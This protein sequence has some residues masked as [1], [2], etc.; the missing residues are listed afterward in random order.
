MKQ[1]I[2]QY[3]VA[4]TLRFKIIPT[5]KTKEILAEKRKQSKLLLEADKKRAKDFK[6]AKEV[7]DRFHRDFI[8][9]VLDKMKNDS[10]IIESLQDCSTED[11]KNELRKKIS[12]RFLTDPLYNSLFGKDLFVQANSEKGLYSFAKN[13]SERDALLAFEGFTIFFAGY[14]E[15]RK[16][17][18]V[19][20]KQT[21][22]IAYRI[23][24][25]NLQKFENN[26]IVF[27][28]IM[29]T[30]LATTLSKNTK[31]KKLLKGKP[32]ED[33]FQLGFYINVW[34]QEEIEY[35][36]DIVGIIN[37]DIKQFNDTLASK[38]SEL[39]LMEK[40]YKQILG[41]KEED[42]N[43]WMFR[44]FNSDKELLK[45]VGQFYSLFESKIAEPLRQLLENINTYDLAGIHIH[46]KSLRTISSSIFD[47]GYAIA[48]TLIPQNTNESY[49]EYKERI[50]KGNKS[51]TIQSVNKKASTNICQY[52]SKHSFKPITEDSDNR[53]EKDIFET[54]KVAY[55]N[56]KEIICNA[57]S[58][59]KKEL[60]GS[61]NEEKLKTLLDSLK[62]LQNFVQP[63]LGKGDEK[64]K[65]WSFYNEFTE[66]WEELRPLNI[67]YDKVR[68]RMTRKPF[69]TDKI[70]VIFDVKRNFLNGWT[71]SMTK[72]DNGTQ[73]GGYIFRKKNA[74]GEYDYY[75]GVCKNAK[76][77]RK[78]DG[79]HGDYERLDYY[80]IDSKTFYKY[81]Y[82]GANGFEE[83]KNSLM[84]AIRSFLEITAQDEN[85][86]QLL[87][88]VNSKDTPIAM[89]TA[90]QE[91][92]QSKLSE[93]LNDKDFAD[94]NKTVIENLR[95]SILSL[96]R[97]PEAQ[98]YKDKEYL[99]F[100]EVQ[101]DIEVL[102][103][104][105][106]VFEYFQV[107]DE[108]IRNAQDDDTKPLLLFK[109]SNKD[110]SYA[111]TYCE[112]K[113]TSRGTENL[114]TMYFKT[115]MEGNQK[116]FDIGAGQI[117][118][119]EKSIPRKVTHKAGVPI[120][121]K[122][123]RVHAERPTRT[124][125][126]DLVKDK[127]YTEDNY[128]FHLS[129]VINYQKSELPKSDK[130]KAVND[131]LC[132]FN[133]MTLEYLRQNKGNVNIIGIDRGERNLI[134]VSL[135]NAKGEHLT[136]E[137]PRSY[138]L[139]G[140]FDYQKKLKQVAKNRD[141][142]RKNWTI[143][144][145]IADIK[146]GYLSQVVHE[147]ASLAVRHHAII[148]MENLSRGFKNGRFPIEHQVYQLFENMLIEKLSYFAFKKD[149]PSEGYGNIINGVQL[150][151][152]INKADGVKQ[153]GWIFYVPAGYTSKIDP[154]TG[155]ADLFNLN[156]AA[157]DIRNF[158]R[159][160]DSIRYENGLFHFEFDYSKQ[161]TK[162]IRKTT[163]TPWHLS[164]HGK[165]I[166]KKELVD[167]TSKFR[168]FFAKS[169]VSISLDK[170][171]IE[172]IC[173]LDDIQLNEFFGLFKLLLKMRN[174]YD[175]Q[176]F[177]ISPV[178]DDKPF[179]TGEGNPMGIKDA[180]ANG[181]YNIAL[182]GLYW[183]Y[184]NFPTDEN[185]YLK[186][187]KDE[188]WFDFIQTKPYLND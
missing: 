188:D 100:S 185:G 137:F 16:N 113:R 117:F 159:A 31:L 108:E 118:F 115:L 72:S 163:I 162:G 109:I 126:Y 17:M 67:L 187:I 110:L 151:V 133:N 103:R 64:K 184:F 174:S 112:G 44:G 161:E 53:E 88:D 177:I 122:N 1:F 87:K 41:F 76:I 69:S 180:D 27:S 181:A 144:E 129:I 37:S 111:E 168:S 114:H 21:T 20:K 105:K 96:S 10:N 13:E 25:V 155:F 75:L 29:K 154:A 90:I 23:V 74:I 91:R 97:I 164:S 92:S 78:R 4:K 61:G 182:K 36:N 160:F 43:D 94:I 167:L 153:N 80:Q 120:E 166:E 99:L 169:D 119:R 183:L 116:V 2:N 38:K 139:I 81:Y 171:S 132:E 7:I 135:L 32:C 34:K 28:E 136:T 165:R 12:E 50:K 11:G 63:L 124:L 93:L 47:D 40:L 107:S 152:P 26:M 79:V 179:I 147:I 175:E 48:R 18:Y 178:A 8:D 86:E 24:N 130:K 54:I 59:S 102:C 3:Q 123:E 82:C 146:K 66:L 60:A 157:K 156:G 19:S 22:A 128:L 148:V 186:Y 125:C 173:N 98:D 45:A 121:N 57:K 85:D 35:Y 83:D 5:K 73:Y 106:R 46:Q 9:S 14:H 141:E 55:E 143:P 127:R 84:K 33:I 51:F 142:E 176:D 150:A 149:S 56:V 68:N 58:Y 170:V 140:N 6:V 71:D 42:K 95:K 52:F 39:P 65:D 15:N 89:I 62:I 30:V 134:Y 101:H 77:L 145:R 104:T 49:E 138:N 131:F 158:F 70:K 172:S